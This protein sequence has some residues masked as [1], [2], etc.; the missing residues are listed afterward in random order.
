MSSYI[1]AICGEKTRFLLRN[2]VDEPVLSPASRH[3]WD[4]SINI[5]ATRGYAFLRRAPKMWFFLNIRDRPWP[6]QK[7]TWGVTTVDRA[8]CGN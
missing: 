3:T 1:T 7:N 6:F 2:T 5:A 4:S 8:V